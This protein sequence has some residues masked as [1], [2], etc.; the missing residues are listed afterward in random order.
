M[1]VLICIIAQEIKGDRNDR[2]KLPEHYELEHSDPNVVFALC[3]G[4]KPSPAVS[5]CLGLNWYK[6]ILGNLI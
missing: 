3:S 5:Y 4:Y 6:F 1:K 2:E